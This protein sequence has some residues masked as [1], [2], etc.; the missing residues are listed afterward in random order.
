MS[1]YQL[2]LLKIPVADVARAAAFYRERLK[3]KET[4]VAAEY[5][6]AQMEAG[7]LAIALYKPGMGGGDGHVGGSTGFQLALPAA[8]FDALAAELLPL[9]V[10]VENQIHKGDDGTTFIQVRD[11][12]GN[13]LNVGRREPTV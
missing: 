10:L 1:D 8:A 5:G 3:F 12:D 6:W 9:G 13:V 2:S 7:A 4:F 11:P